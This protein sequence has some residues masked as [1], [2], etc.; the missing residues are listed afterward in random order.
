M[1]FGVY[2]AGHTIFS[3]MESQGWRREWN[4]VLED[5]MK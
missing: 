2:D 5:G 4:G 3:G 1:F